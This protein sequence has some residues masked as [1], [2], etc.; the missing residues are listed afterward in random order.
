MDL[1]VTWETA[2]GERHRGCLTEDE[3]PDGCDRNVPLVVGEEGNAVR[4]GD[5]EDIVLRVT[6]P[7]TA[8]GERLARSAK[9]AGYKIDWLAAC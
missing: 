2:N 9:S 8:D 7:W 4:P 6:S 3:L 5:L 1:D